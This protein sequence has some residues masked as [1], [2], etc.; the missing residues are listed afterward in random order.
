[1]VSWFNRLVQDLQISVRVQ[2][3]YTFYTNPF[4][5]EASDIPHHGSQS[6][7]LSSLDPN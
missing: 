4:E 1:M 3:M 7:I 5:I 2:F 6:N